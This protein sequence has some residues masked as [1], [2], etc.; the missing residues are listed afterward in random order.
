MNLLCVDWG[1]K[2][3]GLAFVDLQVM[4]PVPLETIDRQPWN[5][6]RLRLEGVCKTR[7]VTQIII[8]WPANLD[9]TPTARCG[10]VASAIDLLTSSGFPPITKQN[11]YG[12]SK[13]ARHN[14]DTLSIKRSKHIDHYAALHIL[15]DYLM[16]TTSVE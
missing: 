11:E 14:C 6:A 2:R 10:M 12:T 15:Q 9:G 4:I 3:I 7:H 16:R 5:A 8:G 13:L 1:Q